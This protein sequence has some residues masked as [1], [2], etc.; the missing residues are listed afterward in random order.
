MPSFPK[1]QYRVKR[2]DWGS[3]RAY[4]WEVL[5]KV[6][7]GEVG[8][9]VQ[10]VDVRSPPEYKGEVTAPP[11]YP[12]EQ[13]QVGGHIPG[14]VNIGWAVDPET[15]RFKPPEELR[16]MFESMGVTPDKEI[17]TYCRIGERAA[18]TWFVLKHILKYPSVTT[19][20]GQSGATSWGAPVEK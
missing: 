11:E 14:A 19:G 7:H 13:T 4:L 20:V 17:V 15:G 9:S 2:V 1:T 16:R 8:R 6:V 18:H 12:N 3:R 5:N 10:L